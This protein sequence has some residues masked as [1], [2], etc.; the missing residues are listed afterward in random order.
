[1]KKD[2]K[3][4]GQAVLVLILIM[5]VALA[6]G[7][8][9]VQKS[10]VDLSTATRVEQS[11]RAFSAAEAGIEKVLKENAN[12]SVNFTENQSSA[13]AEI[14]G[15]L[16]YVVPT[17]TRQSPLEYPSFAKEEFAHI[18]LADPAANLPT[19]TSSDICYKQTTLDIY[20]GNSSEDQAALEISLIYYNGTSYQARRW[21]LDHSTASRA[22]VTGF[23]LVP[24]CSGGYVLP[25]A[26]YQC[27]MRLGDVSVNASK[28]GS[29]PSGLMLLRARF[30]YN[31]TSQPFAVQAP[32]TATCG[33]DCSIPPQARTAVSTGSSGQTK[34]Q[35]QV[36]EINKVVPYYFDFALFSAGAINK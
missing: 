33:N 31:N 35:L 10:L 7:V 1:M 32:T 21:F 15:L 30:L 18:W 17:G 16:P 27:F 8:S 36:F 5:S 4:S 22:S 23:D 9:V 3:N 6:M 19:C 25:N 28:N 11:G 13:I 34:R 12:A 2:L 29:L 20:W 14:T 26:T 24:T